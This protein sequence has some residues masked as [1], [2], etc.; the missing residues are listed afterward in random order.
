MISFLVYFDLIG[1]KAFKKENSA[2]IEQC[3]IIMK[4]NDYQ[5]VGNFYRQYF[6]RTPLFTTKDK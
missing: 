1:C 2:N 5:F 6:T 4:I 3:A